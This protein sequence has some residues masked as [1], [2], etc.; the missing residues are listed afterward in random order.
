MNYVQVL[1]LIAKYAQYIPLAIE[2]GK[3]VIDAIERIGNLAKGA[4]EGSLTQE[5]I[6]ENR[7]ALDEAMDEFNADI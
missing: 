5:E 4:A 2:A 1:E 6:A 3:D 7:K